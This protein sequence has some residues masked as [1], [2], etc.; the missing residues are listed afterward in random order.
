MVLISGDNFC[1]WTNDR[2]ATIIPSILSTY[3]QKKVF[4][5]SY[6]KKNYFQKLNS[7]PRV[8]SISL[9]QFPAY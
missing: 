6:A 2:E 1:H 8:L 3:I 7:V 4:A 9:T 5:A